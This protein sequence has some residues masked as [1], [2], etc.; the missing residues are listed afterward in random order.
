[1][2]YLD[3]FSLEREPRCWTLKDRTGDTFFPIGVS[4]LLQIL[5]QPV[6]QSRFNGH[7]VAFAEEIVPLLR[8]WGFNSVG[9]GGVNGTHDA[10]A[11]HL[12]FVLSVEVM[13][14][15]MW[16]KT[17]FAFD[18]VFTED[19]ESQAYTTIQDALTPYRD[20]PNLIGIHWT[21]T[22]RWRIDY[23]RPTGEDWMSFIRALPAEAPGKQQWLAFLQER[24]STLSEWNRVYGCTLTRWEDL[25]DKAVWEIDFDNA[26]ILADDEAFVAR[27]A[28][29]VYT[30]CKEATRAV[31]DSV[32]ILGERY[33]EPDT[34]PS[35]LAVATRFV[36]VISVQPRSGL[37]FNSKFFDRL[38]VTTDKPIMI[39]DVA[40]SFPPPRDEPTVWPQAASA[41]E[42]G[43]AF[44][45]FVE[46]AKAHPAVIGVSWC[47][48]IDLPR[49][50]NLKQGLV[51]TDLTPHTAL[52]EVLAKR[53][54]R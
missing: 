41:T 30:I 7:L 12:P 44:A 51:D 24:Y 37:A 36:D 18:D 49:A 17:S 40:V 19:W 1:M 54:Y 5:E 39:C 13:Q 10:F 4:H 45:R 46:E 27:V 42:A 38:A 21:D 33:H 32:L 3:R 29:R 11:A 16:R 34:P 35:I 8:A 25:A 53:L 26:Q 22:P 43:E 48:Y 50:T 23:W 15:S 47:T 52:V 9:Y 31:S 14:T 6:L 28:E 20:H 2:A